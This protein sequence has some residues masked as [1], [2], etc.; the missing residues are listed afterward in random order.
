MVADFIVDHSIGKN[1]LDYLELESWK[2][3][4]DGPSHKDGT[5][6]RVLIISPNKIP[7][8]LKYKV[9]GLCSNNEAE[10]EVLIAGLDIFLELGATRVEIMGDW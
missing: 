1:A 4:F 9:E 5:W 3:Y 2:L 6:I 10:Y 7:T 8:K